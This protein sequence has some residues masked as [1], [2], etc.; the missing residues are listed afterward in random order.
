[1]NPHSGSM[2][3]PQAGVPMTQAVEFRGRPGLTRSLRA[4]SGSLEASVFWNLPA[5]PR[6]VASFRI[7]KDNDQNFFQEI[8]DPN[9]RQFLVKLPA[10]TKSRVYVSAVSSLGREGPKGEGIQVQSNTDSY[11][12]SG[13]GGATGGTPSNSP[14]PPE[15]PDEP[16]GGKGE[17]FIL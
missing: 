13:T 6:G 3:K 15:W 10:N 16:T 5:D 12:T 9:C 2:T 1:M 17:T 7:Y 4:Q 14:P 11:V 8:K